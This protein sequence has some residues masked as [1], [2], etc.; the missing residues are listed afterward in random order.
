MFTG[1]VEER[2]RIVAMKA[3]RDGMRLVIAATRVSRGLRRGASIA[4]N[5]ACLSVVAATPPRLSFDV[6]TETLRRTNLGLLLPGDRVN[7][8]RSL[9]AGD[10]IEGHLVQ[11]HV[12]DVGGVAAHHAGADGRWLDI[13]VSRALAPYLVR[14]G[15]ITVDGVSLTLGPCRGR[16]FR[17]FLIPQTLRATTLGG[18]CRG[19]L[20]NVEV[21]LLAKLAARRLATGKKVVLH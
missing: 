3:Q 11:G 6:I 12:D 17:V 18:R 8:E 7:L 19:D 20:V 16:R 14:K 10:R 13:E 4:V 5:G 2:G 9:R 1:I 21:D 15:S